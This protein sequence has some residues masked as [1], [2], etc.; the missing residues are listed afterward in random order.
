MISFPGVIHFQVNIFKNVQLNSYLKNKT[1]NRVSVGPL[2]DGD[3]LV[4]DDS[5]M[6][7]MLNNYFCSVFTNENL[8]NMREPE[9]LYRGDDLVEDVDFT[10][11]K[12][13]QK[14]SALKPT[15]APGP[16]GVWTRILHQLADIL[17]KPLAIIFSKLFQ[18]GVVPDIWRRAHVCPVY[19][20]GTKGDPG[21]YRPVSLTCV[22]C[23]VM[24]SLVRDV[25]VEHLSKHNLIRSSQHGFMAGRSTVTN[26][27]AYMETLTK[28]LDDGHAVDVLYLDFAKAFDK[29]PHSRLLAKCR[30]LGLGG[31]LLQ[32]IERWLLDR[33]QRVILNG[34]FSAWADVLSG[35]PQGSVLG[36]TLFIIFINDIDLA[37]DV[38]GSFL[39]KFADDTKVGMVVENEN[40][41]DELQAAIAELDQ[42]SAEWQMMF[43]SSKCH[44]LH[45]GNGNLRFEYVM[46]GQVLEAVESEKDVGVM[47]HQSLKPSLQCARAAERANQV[48]GQ[49]SRA[50][51]YRDKLTFLKLYKVYVRPHLEY[52]VASWSPW[53]QSDKEMLEKV[54]RRAINMVSNFQARNYKEKLLEAGMTSLEQRR[55]RG[56][57]IHMYRIMTGKDDVQP[58]TWFQLMADRDG[59]ANT[60]AAAG[61]LNVLNPDNSN[62]DIRRNFFSQRVVQSWNSLPDVVKMSQTVNQFKNSLDDFKAWG[63]HLPRA[64]LHQQ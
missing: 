18:E 39:F 52:A 49:L 4:T 9:Q 21:N 20:K 55:E 38:T 62:S 31:K 63:G 46:G 3:R 57:L 1:S 16:D 33:K 24:E 45:L 15:A 51:T 43:N 26:L 56:D 23:K 10:D 34:S 53:L 50:V 54:Q 58:S 12:V 22:L 25:I 48:L 44:I 29:V 36:P 41:R 61:H 13:K 14:L 6:A 37:I 40:Q 47:I 17:A 28:L 35:V 30:G 5:E 32:W 2:K 19:K 59:G 64:G 27:L 7:E 8:A 60:R 11:E 42:W